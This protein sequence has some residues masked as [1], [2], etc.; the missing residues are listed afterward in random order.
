MPD[1]EILGIFF[2]GKSPM[3]SES[4]SHPRMS[5]GMLI[6]ICKDSQWLTSE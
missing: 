5:F 4:L 3:E 1:P 6:P 2:A